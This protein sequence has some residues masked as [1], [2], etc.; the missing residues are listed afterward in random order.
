MESIIQHGRIGKSRL[1]AEYRV[2]AGMPHVEL[3]F[4]VHWVERQKM[5]KLTLDFPSAAAGRFDGIMDGEVERPMDG[6][7]CPLR[8]R[9]IVELENGNRLGVIC[10][11]VFALDATASRLRLTLLRSS[12]MAHHVPHAGTTGREVIADQGTQKFRLRFVYG[13]DVASAAVDAAALM[14]QRPLIYAD[15]TRGMPPKDEQITVV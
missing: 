7:E 6:R 14:M 5:L 1:T 12:I 15:L 11:H 13:R 9:T 2:Y 8:D 10:P 3:L 4:R